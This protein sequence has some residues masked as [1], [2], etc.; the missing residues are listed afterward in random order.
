LLHWNNIQR[1]ARLHLGQR[2]RLNV[3]ESETTASAVPAGSH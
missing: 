2:L 1:T 3:I